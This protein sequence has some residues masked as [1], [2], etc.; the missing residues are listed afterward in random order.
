[1][2]AGVYTTPSAAVRA[3]GTLWGPKHHDEQ[4][5]PAPPYKM[6]KFPG[7]DP[8]LASRALEYA[9][10]VYEGS[11]KKEDR[12]ESSSV[13]LHERCKPASARRHLLPRR[14]PPTKPPVISTLCFCYSGFRHFL[15]LQVLLGL[16]PQLSV[17][18]CR[19]KVTSSSLQGF[20][21]C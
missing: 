17:R 16:L 15:S 13:G 6:T 20:R 8:D 2:P 9:R 7:P 12:G 3:L 21:K 4:F 11:G 14:R 10:W 5:S 19:L 1:M 18:R